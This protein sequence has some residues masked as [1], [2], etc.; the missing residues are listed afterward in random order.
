MVSDAS[1]DAIGIALRVGRSCNLT[2]WATR[3]KLTDLLD[4]AKGEAGA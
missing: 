3:L 1:D 4:R 2:Q